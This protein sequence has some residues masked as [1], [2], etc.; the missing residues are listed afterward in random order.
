MNDFFKNVIIPLVLTHPLSWIS[1]CFSLPERQGILEGLFVMS[2]RTGKCL[3]EWSA[4]GRVD[5]LSPWETSICIPLVRIRG[6]QCV[7][8]ESLIWIIW[9]WCPLNRQGGLGKKIGT[10]HRIR[11]KLISSLNYFSFF[12]C[13][14]TAYLS[15]SFFTCT[16]I[17][18]SG[19][20]GEPILRLHL[21]FDYYWRSNVQTACKEVS[22]RPFLSK[23]T[24]HHGNSLP[25]ALRNL[26]IS[27]DGL[28][29]WSWASDFTSLNPNFWSVTSFSPRHLIDTKCNSLPSLLH[30][31]SEACAGSHG[32][33]GRRMRERDRKTQR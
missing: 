14:W 1:I 22:G 17:S 12:P 24:C 33:G 26:K 3:R 28:A 11:S 16:R 27:S 5:F 7:E 25:V 23:G 32:S 2:Q 13:Y 6:T 18:I 21:S 31:Y 10:T 9:A 8:A 20:S 29:L 19:F 30:F 15:L 4:K